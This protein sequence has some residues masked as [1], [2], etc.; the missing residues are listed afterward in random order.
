MKYNT[1][2]L[3]PIQAFLQANQGR[4]YIWMQDNAP[5]H[6]SR[7]TR[8]A[9]ELRRIPYIRWPRFSPDLNLIEHVWT[10]IKNY[11]Q[12]HYYTAYYDCS[13]IPLEQ[14]RLIIQEAWDAVPNSFIENLYGSWWR[15]CEAVITA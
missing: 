13:K 11:I 5:S 2:I 8:R 10:S 7:Y 4:G 9:L 15:R 3:G 12:R 6:R 1:I 14:L